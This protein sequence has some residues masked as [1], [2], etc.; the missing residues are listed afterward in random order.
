MGQVNSKLTD[1]VD[2]ELESEQSLFSSK[3]IGMNTKQV[4]V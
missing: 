2:C 1:Y 4:S 3:S